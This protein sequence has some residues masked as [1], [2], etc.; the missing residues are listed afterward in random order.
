MLLVEFT[1]LSG[2]HKFVD[3][4]ENTKISMNEW[5]YDYDTAQ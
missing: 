2:K 3:Y 1:I 5:I 4:V